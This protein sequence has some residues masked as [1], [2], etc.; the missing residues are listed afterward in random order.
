VHGAKIRGFTDKMTRKR[1]V[2]HYGRTF[3]ETKETK[4]KER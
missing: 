1:P 3:D 4:N 2:G